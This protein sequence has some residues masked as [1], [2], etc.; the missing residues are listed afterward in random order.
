[1]F[2]F[3]KITELAHQAVSQVIRSGDSVI[4]ATAGNGLDT[5]FLALKTGS[6]GRVYAFDIQEE[7]LF[8]TAEI[9]KEKNLIQRVSLIE[10]GH[11]KIAKHVNETVS[12]VMYNLGYL[13]GGSS[14]ITTRLNTTLQSFQQALALLQPGGIITLVLYPGHKE[15]RIEKDG[16]MPFFSR[17]STSEYTVLH[18]NYLN[19]S[20]DPPELVIV[21]KSF[22][23]REG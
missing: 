18:Y 13:P 8:R 2:L 10:A 23:S 21:Q 9:L 4:D 17:L 12:V 15:G 19:K 5:I 11:E 1:M 3:H 6:R 7:A 14:G 16:L 22:F 20:S